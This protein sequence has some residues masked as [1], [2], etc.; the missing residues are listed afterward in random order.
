MKAVNRERGWLVLMLGVLAC[1]VGTVLAPSAHAATYSVWACADGSGKR[2]PAADWQPVRVS[3]RVSLVESS[4][5][6]PTLEESPAR[7]RAKVTSNALNPPTWAG[8]GWKVDAAPATSIMGLDLWWT[9]R[10]AITGTREHGQIDISAPHTIYKLEAA[11]EQ[12][13]WFGYEAYA[14][15]SEDIAYSESNHQ[16]YRGMRTSNVTLMA[17]CVEFCYVANNVGDG[18]IGFFDAFRIKTTVGDA[19]APT[20]SE[21]GLQDGARISAASAVHAHANDIGGGVREISLRVDDRIVDRAG[22]DGECADVDTSNNDPYEY[23]RMLPCPGE[24]SA[25]LTL[26]PAH[27]ADGHRHVVSVV[28][29]DAAGQEVVIGSAR[30]ALAAPR[31]FFASSGFVNPDLD[32][33]AERKLN[34]VHAG[35][36]S[37]RM[38]FVV[39]STKR[40]RFVAQRVVT[41]GARQRIIGRLTSV[42]GTPIA[43][44]RVWRAAAVRSGL[45]QISGGPLTTSAT[46]RVSARLPAR[47]PGREVRLVYFPFSDRSDNVQSPS[48]QLKVRASTTINTDQS[49]YRNGDT[50]RFSGRITTLPIAPRK[51]VYLQVIVRGRWRTFGTT[52]A[53]PTG[54]WRL[55]YRFTA[56]RQLTAYRFR[57][58]VPAEDQPVSWATGYSP[59]LRVLVSP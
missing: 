11:P 51:P 5:S 9:A 47:L 32:V 37:L 1:L 12:G 55:S 57:A 43:G 4:C 34:G 29:T 21:T 25:E 16:T 23:A 42:L 2:Q 38:S 35:P 52:R 19:A 8:T 54:R 17:W 48:R 31:G 58:V 15:G 53:S 6:D 22:S 14:P 40:R 33:L 24:R 44:A 39:G 30:V 3:N 10:L 50:M 59:A 46:G 13:N 49:G 20:G 41:T 28:A 18:V 56:T 45:W 26:S 7:L 36:A 27:L